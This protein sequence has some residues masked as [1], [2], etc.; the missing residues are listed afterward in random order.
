MESTATLKKIKIKTGVV[1]R[2][3][4]EYK[5]YNNEVSKLTEKLEV[6][7][8]ESEDAGKI[9]QT[10]EVLAESMAMLPN[11]KSRIQASID[12]LEA[13]MVGTEG[14]E[15]SEEFINAEKAI[16]EAKAFLE[17]IWLS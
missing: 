11:C 3:V 14:L 10:E 6:L 16:S 17:M 5:G 7:K 9:R 12:D 1:T 4:K 15:E 13:N 8:A 2:N